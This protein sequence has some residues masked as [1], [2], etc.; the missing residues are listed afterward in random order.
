MFAHKLDWNV[1]YEG[2][3]EPPSVSDS[4]VTWST[5]DVNSTANYSCHVGHQ[6]QGAAQLICHINSSWISNDLTS[7]E[8][9][10]C[11]SKYVTER[12]AYVR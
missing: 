10:S 3:D 2:C 11:S 12:H 1:G 7:H 9:P 5:S 8:P 4:D 6:L